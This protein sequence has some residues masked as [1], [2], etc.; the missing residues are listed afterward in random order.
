MFWRQSGISLWSLVRIDCFFTILREKSLV[1]SQSSGEK[2]VF[3]T[4]HWRKLFPRLFDKIQVSIRSFDKILFLLQSWAFY[5]DT[6]T[7]II[8]FLRLFY[9]IISSL[10]SLTEFEDSF[11]K[12]FFIPP[13]P[14]LWRSS[15]YFL[16][17][18][19]NKFFSRDCLTNKRLFVPFHCIKHAF[20][21]RFCDKISEFT[22]IYWRNRL[23]YLENW[24]NFNVIF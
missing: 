14:I 11:G 5:F 19:T 17:R 12:S 23:F 6:L 4:M 24:Q 20:L 16:Q 13:F 18:L 10:D 7:K 9:K 2:C 1:V 22:L 3:F 8:I 21:E 15:G